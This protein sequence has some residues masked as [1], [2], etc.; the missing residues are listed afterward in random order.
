MPGTYQY[1]VEIKSNVAKLLSDMK[2]VQDRL[3]TVEG[4]EY[5]IKLNVDEKKLSSVISNLEKMLDSLSKGTGDFKQFENLSKELSNIVSEVQ[6]L[7]K[8]FGKVDDSGAKTLLSS[9]TIYLWLISLTAS[10]ELS[11]LLLKLY[12]D[13]AI[14]ISSSL[15]GLCVR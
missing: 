7:S 11:I 3:D 5:K 10:K 6:S 9:T 14:G 12:N 1:D 15:L 8:A 13:G 2:Q 4:K